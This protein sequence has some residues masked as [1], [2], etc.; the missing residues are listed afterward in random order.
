MAAIPQANIKASDRLSFTIF[1]A[2]A[3]HVLMVLTDF[4]QD[5]PK[6]VAKTMEITLARFD[7]EKR[8]DQADFLAQTNQQGSGNVEEKVRQSSPTKSIDESMLIQESASPAKPQQQETEKRSAV[9][10]RVADDSF[11]ALFAPDQEYVPDSE[12]P[13]LRSLIER[14]LQIAELEASYEEQ[15]QQYA[16]KPRVTRLAAASTMKAVDARYVE[17][18]VAKIERVGRQFFPTD[19]GRKLYGK[20]RVLISIYSDGSLRDVEIRSSSGDLVLDAKTKDIV[21]RAAPF[22]PFPS[23]VRKERDVL[24]LIRTFSYT[25]KGVYSF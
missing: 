18:V 20:P 2:I 7:D 19:R 21:S 5:D 25:G 15:L 8:P 22:A 11:S 13:E 4:I 24:E 10:T 9:V 17:Q 16:K 3:L 14:S 23:E 6:P 12:Q 1:V